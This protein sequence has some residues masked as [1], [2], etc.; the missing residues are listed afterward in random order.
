MVWCSVVLRGGEEGDEM[1]E[2]GKKGLN[3]RSMYVC[4]MLLASRIGFTL[5]DLPLLKAAG[6]NGRGSMECSTEGSTECTRDS[7]D[8]D[9]PIYLT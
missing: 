2:R 4:Y 8:L 5:D 9:I 7:E 6:S 1:R 3:S